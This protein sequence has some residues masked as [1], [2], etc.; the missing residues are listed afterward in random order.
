[1]RARRRRER[2]GGE[3]AEDEPERVADRDRVGRRRGRRGRLR[4]GV[5]LLKLCSW[6]GRRRRRRRFDGRR[7]QLDVTE[8]DAHLALSLLLQEGVCEH[9][10][11]G[12]ADRAGDEGACDGAREDRVV[13]GLGGSPSERDP[14][15]PRA[16]AS[17]VGREQRGEADGRGA[18]CLVLLQDVLVEGGERELRLLHLF[19]VQVDLLPAVWPL[20]CAPGRPALGL[21]RPAG[22]CARE[23]GG[24]LQADG[25]LLWPLGGL[26]V[27]CEHHVWVDVPSRQQRRR[28]VEV[29]VELLRRREVAHLVQRHLEPA[30]VAFGGEAVRHEGHV[31]PVCAALP[32]RITL[33][34]LVVRLESKSGEERR[35]LDVEDVLRRRRRR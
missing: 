31:A 19:D 7:L 26:L 4:L 14:A 2:G 8:G 11:G 23:V 5:S 3:R 6:F 20:C 29:E 16:A 12:G 22:G 28:V 25:A 9:A 27:E 10:A 15:A 34:R 32:P 18:E 17:G 1:M 13:L 33:F 30:G 24:A 21:A 35:G